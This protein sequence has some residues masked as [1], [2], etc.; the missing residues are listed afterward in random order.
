[1][2]LIEIKKVTK[3]GQAASLVYGWDPKPPVDGIAA[4]VRDETGTEWACSKFPSMIGAF[5]KIDAQFAPNGLPVFVH[6]TGSVLSRRA[7]GR[8]LDTLNDSEAIAN[9]TGGLS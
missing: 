2:E 7:E 6:G 4:V 1:M 5:W 9:L 3:P 8:L